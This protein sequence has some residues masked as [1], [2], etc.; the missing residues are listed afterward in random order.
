MVTLLQD[1]NM[2]D[3]TETERRILDAV[4]AVVH[5]DG[6]SAIGINRIAAKAECSKVLIYRYF[7]GIDG[8]LSRWAEDNNYWIRQG[9]KIDLSILSGAVIE[10]KKRFTSDVF[11]GQL[12][13]VRKG[14]IM[15]E[16]LRWQLSEDHPVCKMMMERAEARG[17]ALTRAILENTETD[18]DIEAMIAIIVGGIFFLTL[19]ADFAPVYNGV[20][21][22]TEDG[23]ERIEKAI[24]Q[25]IDMIFL[26]IK[27]KKN[28]II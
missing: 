15:R 27:E 8:L 4:T 20:S 2:K 14:E 21:L 9:Q 12:N 19:S 11:I 28:E 17:L 23:W 7:D 1:E 16:L 13:E 5:E 22:E 25:L 3:R 26:Q 18:L 10:D 6:I 24:D